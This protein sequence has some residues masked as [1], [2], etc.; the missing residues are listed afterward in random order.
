MSIKM[1]FVVGPLWNSS[2]LDGLSGHGLKIKAVRSR[3]CLRQGF[4]SQRV[5]DTPDR[6]PSSVVEASSINVF[7]KRLDDWNKGVDY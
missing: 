4:F 7:K 1:N 2:Q 3:L 6:L 5:V